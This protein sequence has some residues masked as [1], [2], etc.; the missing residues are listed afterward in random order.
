MHGARARRK[1]AATRPEQPVGKM[2]KWIHFV[3]LAGLAYWVFGK[4]L[5]PVFRKKAE[6]ISEAITKATAAKAKPNGS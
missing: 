4:L 1:R 5:P 6:L 2:F 3:I